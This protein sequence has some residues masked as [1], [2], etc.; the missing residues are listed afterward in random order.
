[1]LSSLAR[2][3]PIKWHKILQGQSDDII[4]AMYE[5]IIEEIV[6]NAVVQVEHSGTRTGSVVS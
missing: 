6:A 5:A 4:N 2:Y 3:E 1:M